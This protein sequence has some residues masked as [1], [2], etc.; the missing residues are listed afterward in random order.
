MSDIDHHARMAAENIR[1]CAAEIVAAHTRPC[2]VFRAVV[3]SRR[4]GW[5]T[6]SYGD[7]CESGITPESACA[8]FDVAWLTRKNPT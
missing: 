1:I 7:V 2:V 8:A 6:A 4:D 3:H 5:Y